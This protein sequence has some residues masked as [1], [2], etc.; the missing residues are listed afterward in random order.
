MLDISNKENCFN[1]IS[2]KISWKE[3]LD[4]IIKLWILSTISYLRKATL[5][6]NIWNRLITK[7]LFL[8]H[9]LNVTYTQWWKSV[10]SLPQ[11][12]CR[13]KQKHSL[14]IHVHN[15]PYHDWNP[16]NKKVKCSCYQW[17]LP[18]VVD[19]ILLYFFF[20][21]NNYRIMKKTNSLKTYH[22]SHFRANTIHIW[23]TFINVE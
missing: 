5:H 19:I 16:S 12:Q 8:L 2:S 7:A 14:L 3:W 18:F 15:I 9:R 10:C 21:T 4:F 23:T 6:T 22:I 1:L 17:L 13:R 11:P 20:R